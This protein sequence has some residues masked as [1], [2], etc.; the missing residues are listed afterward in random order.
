MTIDEM[1]AAPAPGC[2]DSHHRR[3]QQRR[4]RAHCSS[5]PGLQ[6]NV[7]STAASPAHC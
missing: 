6:R 1:L 5:T 7:T 2:A 3:P 4:R